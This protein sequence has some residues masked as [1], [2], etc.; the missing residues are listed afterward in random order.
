MTAEP[1]ISEILY[2]QEQGVERLSSYI[3][4]LEWLVLTAQPIMEEYDRAGL[5][6]KKAKR[7]V[8]R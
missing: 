8:E 4:T 6:M 5:W 3:G 1:T 7:T 2:Q